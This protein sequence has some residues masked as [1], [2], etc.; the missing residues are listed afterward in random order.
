[1]ETI[2]DNLKRCDA[3]Y[4]SD[5]YQFLE[6]HHP[7]YIANIFDHLCEDP[8]A[9]D[10]SLY[11]DLSNKFQLSARKDHLIDVVEGRKIRLAADIICG[12]KQIADFHNNDYEKWRKDYELVRSNLNLHFLWP[13]H[14]PPT[15]NTYR[16]TKYLDRIDYLLFDLK[17]YFKGQEN[18][19]NLNTPM[20]DA[21]ESE[22][23]AIWLRQFN[24]DFKYFI[25]KMK[26][27][28]FVNDNYD[29]LDISTG[30]TEIIQGIISLKEISETLNLYMENLLRLNSQNVFN[31]ECPPTQD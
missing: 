30:Q 27:Q 15:I 12:R 25:D 29:V 4:K 3:F 1:L 18:Q 14:K 9:G 5:F 2:K 10:V 23:T 17:C 6:N 24:S 7:N 21:Y 19:E 16:Y 8:D 28:A 11:Q 26:L 22:K 31:K 13:K 20:K